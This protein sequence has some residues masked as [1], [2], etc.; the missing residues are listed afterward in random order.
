MSNIETRNFSL[1]T[2]IKKTYDRLIK[3]VMMTPRRNMAAR[4]NM[5]AKMVGLSRCAAYSVTPGRCEAPNSGVLLH[6]RISRFRVWSFGPSRNDGGNLEHSP[7]CLE[8]I[9]TAPSIRRKR[10]S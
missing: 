8:A 4:D 3:G 7:V 6:M 10:R 2:K 5:P 1:E 9:A